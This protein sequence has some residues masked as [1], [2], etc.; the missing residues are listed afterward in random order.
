MKQNKKYVKN[1][2][3]P[4][5]RLS[6]WTL[7]YPVHNDGTVTLFIRL[8]KNIDLLHVPTRTHSFLL[9][10]IYARISSVSYMNSLYVR[11]LYNLQYGLTRKNEHYRGLMMNRVTEYV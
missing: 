7:D 5:T 6:Y 8:T 10:S 9:V 1:K 2:E 11:S 4:I 3:D